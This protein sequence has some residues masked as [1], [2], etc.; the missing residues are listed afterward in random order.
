MNPR[1]WKSGSMAVSHLISLALLATLILIA[2]LL[3]Q[4]V[5]ET[6]RLEAEWA[7]AEHRLEELKVLYP[8]YG[9]LTLLDKPTQW[10]GLLPPEMQPLAESEVVA[11]P[12]RFQQLAAECGLELVSVAPQVESHAETGCR[13]L[14]VDLRVTG[15]YAQF[16]DLWM[17]MEQMPALARVA[18]LEIRRETLNEQIDVRAHLALAP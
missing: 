10:P 4:P 5:Q 3:V 13:Y 16:R 15:T 14:A 1:T 12:E 7:A 17:A 11:I 9:E 2:G 8:L 6:W 18:K